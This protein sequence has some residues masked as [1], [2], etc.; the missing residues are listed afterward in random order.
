MVW[1]SLTA[2]RN[3]LLLESSLIFQFPKD[4]L[5]GFVGKFAK[6][7][8]S[9]FA[10]VPV[11]FVCLFICFCLFVFFLCGI[12]LT[13][14]H[15][16]AREGREHFINSSLPLPPASQTL[17]HWPAGR[18]LQRA[19]QVFERKP[20]LLCSFCIVLSAFLV[21]LILFNFDRARITFLIFFFIKV[22]I[23]Y[24][25]I[26]SFSGEYLFKASVNT[27]WKYE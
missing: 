14:N 26:L 21:S 1:C 22:L 9:F 11:M 8:L 20:L 18:L 17:R 23:L 3:F 24:L 10:V 12:S 19:H 25:N 27:F 6:R 15:R 5:F 13:N 4:F 7:F 2:F 16:T